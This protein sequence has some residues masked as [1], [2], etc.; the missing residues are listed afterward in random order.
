MTKKSPEQTPEQTPPAPEPTP[1]SGAAAPPAPPEPPQPSAEQ[2]LAELEDK[3]RRALAELAN[4]H[5][6][7][8][9]EREHLGNAAVAAFVRKLLPT[10]DDLAR[11]LKAARE[12]QDVAALIE[13]FRLIESQLLQVLAD[14]GVKPIDC[15]G[16]PF[17]PEVHHAITM[18]T[19]TAF[20]P[21]TVTEELGRGFAMGN[22]V[23]RPAQVKVAAAPQ[24]T[25]AAH[26]PTKKEG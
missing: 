20:P 19:T 14:S 9:K 13:G 10:L 18:D 6:R 25:D 7:H 11:S 3:Y 21:G 17:D 4:V 1:Q 5:K 2:K 8:A 15:V 12:S 16:K 22:F 23:I 24:P 26:N